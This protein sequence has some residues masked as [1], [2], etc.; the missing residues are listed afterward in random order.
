MYEYVIKN[1]N[2]FAKE[3]TNGTYH[4]GDIRP[5]FS[6]EDANTF[7]REKYSTSVTID[8]EKLGWFPKVPEF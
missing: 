4:E 7:Y 8:T 1:F 2:K 3:V 5:T 6:C